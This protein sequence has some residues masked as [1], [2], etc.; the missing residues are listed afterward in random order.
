M[1]RTPQTDGTDVDVV[2]VLVP[3]CNMCG[4]PK[5]HNICLHCDQPCV[6]WRRCPACRVAQSYDG[7]G[8]KP[9]T[10]RG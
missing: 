1:A 8:P 2:L 10:R 3:T 4:L 6:R 5:P 7:I 9:G